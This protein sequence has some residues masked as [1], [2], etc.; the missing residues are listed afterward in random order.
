MA[1]LPNLH[2]KLHLPQ[3][4]Y[5]VPAKRGGYTVI[6]NGRPLH[7]KIDPWG[8]AR[9]W[10]QRQKQ[11]S[12]D[13][14]IIH[15]AG[16]GYVLEEILSYYQE[17]VDLIPKALF[18][19]NERS[20]LFALGRELGLVTQKAPFPIYLLEPNNS[21]DLSP[22]LDQIDFEASRG[23][24]IWRTSVP[25]TGDSI[26][27]RL[28]QGFSSKLSDLLTRVEFEKSWIR[29]ISQNALMLPHTSSVK[30]LFQSFRQTPIVIAGAGPTL[31]Q[32]LPYLR[33]WQDKALLLATD[34]ALGPMLRQ[35]VVPHI[36]FTLDSQ[37]HSLWHFLPYLEGGRLDNI[38]LVADLVAYARIPRKWPGPVWFA[39]TAK[40]IKE[41][42]AEKRVTT[43][44]ADW[45]EQRSHTVGDVQS[46]G[47]V[48]TSAFDLARLMGGDPV[49]FVGQDLA[50]VGREIH[51]RG[52]HHLDKWLA[53]SHRLQ[54]LDSINQGVI[55]KRSSQRFP[56]LRS[57]SNPDFAGETVIGD[58]VF[59]LYR[60]WFEEAFGLC[61][62]DILFPESA[63]AL[64]NSA[65]S[66]TLEQVDK[67]VQGFNPR[68]Y[69]S[70]LNQ[71][72]FPGQEEGQLSQDLWLLHKDISEAVQKSNA[73][74]DQGQATAALS[75]LKDIGDSYPFIRVLLRRL[76]ILMARE[77][78]P[79]DDRLRQWLAGTLG[80]F[81]EFVNSLHKGLTSN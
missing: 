71:L 65:H 78:H 24:R 9:R 76:N 56:T 19:V 3:D 79:P 77:E 33:R 28:L 26:V 55:N 70:K 57:Q 50:Y 17:H 31:I 81:Q 11:G 58:H 72:Y 51:A 18:L 14:L 23:Y 60:H 49:I 16:L 39:T 59:G 21:H 6:I 25:S 46:G 13:I 45:I 27:N 10:F 5:I 63:G 12:A 66:Q 15:E 29:Q 34:T 8:E 22:I 20:G 42:G 75:T 2:K 41:N 61:D 1:E 68:D 62:M 74:L 32:S 38:H 48:A 80:D 52:T 47:S 36:V 4:W 44:M 37:K 54:N 53:L 40:Y 7:S 43:P 30:Y 67:Y 64:I 35:G 73:Q 69:S